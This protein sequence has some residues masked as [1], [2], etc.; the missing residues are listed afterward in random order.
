MIH[1]KFISNNDNNDTYKCN[2]CSDIIENDKI[3][4]L[5]CDP[6]KHIFCYDCIFDWYKELKINK[7]SEYNCIST[8]C[9]ICRKNGGLLPMHNNYSFMQ[10]IHIYNN[11]N[12]LTGICGAKFSTKT[13]YCKKIGKP[14]YGGF[15]VTHIKCKIEDKYVDESDVM[16]SSVASVASIASMDSSASLTSLN[17]TSSNICGFKYKTKNGY[18]G[19]AGK[20][21]YGGLC[22]LHSKCINII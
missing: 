10:G 19:Y 16:L 17:I 7:K 11:L 14:C 3:I 6:S 5:G 9:P 21:K 13:G 2:I 12:N 4:A 18:C 20:S 8:M 15:C 22:G 1:A